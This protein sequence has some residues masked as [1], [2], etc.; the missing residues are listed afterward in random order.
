[1][2]YGKKD[3]GAFFISRVKYTLY[4]NFYHKN[5]VEVK[6]ECQLYQAVRSRYTGVESA[7]VPSPIPPL[8]SCV[9]SQPP[10]TFLTLGSSSL[11][12]EWL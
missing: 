10:L 9:A 11:F 1:M 3:W 5:M 12:G 6:L 4:C 8:S 2:L 7:W